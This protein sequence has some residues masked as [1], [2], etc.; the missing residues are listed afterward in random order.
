MVPEHSSAIWPGFER[1][2]VSWEV[3]DFVRVPDGQ[4]LAVKDDIGSQ[5]PKIED[6]PWPRSA[7]LRRS[8]LAVATQARGTVLI[9]EKMFENRC[10]S[11]TRS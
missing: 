1:L 9:F 11:S 5:I 3:G 4:E 10:S 2:G 8:R 7:D 6:G